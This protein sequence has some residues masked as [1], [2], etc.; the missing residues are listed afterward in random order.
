[1]VP[2]LVILRDPITRPASS[3][4]FFVAKP[5]MQ[6]QGQHFALVVTKKGGFPNPSP[7]RRSFPLF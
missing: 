2:L 3:A 6:R 7:V 1:M 4:G 5:Q